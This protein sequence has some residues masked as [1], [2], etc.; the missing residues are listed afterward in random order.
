MNRSLAL[1]CL[2]LA[3]GAAA[4]NSS[5][6]A[7]EPAPAAPGLVDVQAGPAVVLG[8]VIDAST[9]APL[10]GAVVT[11]PDG[12]QATTD[13]GGRFRLK[14][15]AT[16]TQGALSATAGELSG[17]VRLRPLAG[18]RLEVVIYVR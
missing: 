10:P 13:S 6:A 11:G 8:T 1:L 16:G 17:A 4:C 14:G 18:G 9:G 12:S 15:M 7:A 5:D 3:G 2:L